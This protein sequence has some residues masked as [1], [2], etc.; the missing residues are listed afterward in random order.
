[1]P[2]DYFIKQTIERLNEL[3]DFDWDCCIV[4]T[5]PASS[6]GAHWNLAL[7][8]ITRHRLQITLWEPYSHSRYSAHIKA[9]L[10]K[11]LPG[12]TIHS[13]TTGV[14]KRGDGWR[15]GYICVW[16]QLTVMKLIEEGQAPRV[17]QD[18][19]P[20]PELWVSLVWKVLRE[21]NLLLAMNVHEVIGAGD[22]RCTLA[23]QWKEC[24]TSGSLTGKQLQSLQVSL[25]EYIDTAKVW[26][27]NRLC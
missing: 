27:S 7:W 12:S 8:R 17:W 25:D 24:M 1:M 14:Q 23:P 20:P 5:A 4:N 11:A 3:V 22:V 18:P 13:F 6:S 19:T 9:E 10:E 2:Y 21:R 26:C 15:C 16:W